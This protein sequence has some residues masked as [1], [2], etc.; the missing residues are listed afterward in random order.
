MTDADGCLQSEFIDNLTYQYGTNSN[1]LLNV[2][3]SRPSPAGDEGYKDLGS[4]QNTYDANGNMTAYPDKS[5][6]INYN[7]LNLPEDVILIRSGRGG[8]LNVLIKFVYDA[9]GNLLQRITTSYSPLVYSKT[10]DYISGVEYEDGIVKKVLHA[11]GYVGYANDTPARYY[12]TINDHLGNTRLVYSDINENGKIED[13]T[14]ILQENHY[15]PFGMKMKGAWMGDE[16]AYRYKYNGIEEI[17]D[18]GLDLSFATFRTLDP[19]IGR[20][21]QVDPKAEHDFSSSPYSSMYNDPVFFTDPDGDCPICPFLVAAAVGGLVNL[22]SQALKGNVGSFSE[23]LGYFGSGAV[24]GISDF[25]APGSGRL[26]QPLLNKTQQS[27]Q[28]DFS[29]SDL[30]T[31]GDWAG[32]ALDVGTDALSGGTSGI[33]KAINAAWFTSASGGG[34]TV[35]AGKGLSEGVTLADEIVVSAPRIGGSAASNSVGGLTTGGGNI[36]SLFRAVS[37]AELDDIA[38][39][40]IRTLP[41]TGY[42]TGKLFATTLDD[43]ARFGR[44]NFTFDKLPNHLI[45]VDVPSNVMQN[46]LRFTADGMNAVSI[47]ANQLGKL[48]SIF[49]FNFSPL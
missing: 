37:Q 10:Y 3:D 46:S 34:G 33:T 32:F 6:T 9:A 39:H 25:V 19:S 30:N 23:G 29:F 21:L 8:G 36:T 48:Q 38:L 31:V 47:P 42:E 43:A 40:G 15:Y 12:Y 28:G 22:G 49:K 7:H 17:D 24:S 18:F 20:W 27:L 44:G 13:E 1:Q 11:E 41:R 26:V 14:E 35:L 5:I 16:N 4:G 45:R 2:T